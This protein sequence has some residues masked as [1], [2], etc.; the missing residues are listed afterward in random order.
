MTSCSN[1]RRY[2]LLLA[3]LP[4]LF[5]LGLGGGVVFCVAPGGHLQLEAEASDCCAA[6]SPA[7]AG[8]GGG[9]TLSPDESDCGPCID[10]S[11]AL[12]PRQSKSSDADDFRLTAAE[13][14]ALPGCIEIFALAT[15]PLRALRRPLGRDR[16]QHQLSQLRSV[17]LTC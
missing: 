2:V 17:V 11:V 16:G 9:L 7:T 5:V 4:Q 13:P 8:L 14:L 10:F 3:L 12:D 6:P 15:D 1:P